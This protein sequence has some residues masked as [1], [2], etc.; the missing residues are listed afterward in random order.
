MRNFKLLLLTSLLLLQ[1][2]V[3]QL[4]ASVPPATVTTTPV[5]VA[6]RTNALTSRLAE[7]KGMDK[8][9]LSAAEKK[10]LRKEKRSVKSELR[11]VRG[12]VY[13]SVGALLVLLIILIILL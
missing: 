1:V 7:I 12:G 10:Q 6:L 13:V 4:Y 5:E 9:G 11:A 8:S 3:S 2:G